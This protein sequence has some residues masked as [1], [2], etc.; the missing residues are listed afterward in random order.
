MK[1]MAEGRVEAA[2]RLLQTVDDADVGAEMRAATKNN[3]ASVLSKMGRHEE[4]LDYALHAIDSAKQ[5]TSGASLALA[6]HNV[7][8]EMDFLGDTEAALRSYEHAKTLALDRLGPDHQFTKRVSASL[9][10]QREEILRR[11]MPRHDARPR[12]TRQRRQRRMRNFAG[13]YERFAL[14]CVSS[15][16]FVCLFSK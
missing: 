15:S 3:L 13:G 8:V 11:N 16:L 5:T 12:R 9:A 2:L 7:A 1:A 4:A 6:L 14:M 10:K